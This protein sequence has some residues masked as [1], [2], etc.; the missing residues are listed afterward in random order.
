MRTVKKGVKGIAKRVSRLSRVDEG[1]TKAENS[2]A[3]GDAKLSEEAV[4]I[5][6]LESGL[7]ATPNRVSACF[8]TGAASSET[9]LCWR[10]FPNQVPRGA[11]AAAQ[12]KTNSAKLNSCSPSVESAPPKLRSE[13]AKE[14]R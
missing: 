8:P 7:F 9:K 4:R 1:D 13:R 11:I 2:L 5:S 14:A 6:R 12:T 10:C 3:G